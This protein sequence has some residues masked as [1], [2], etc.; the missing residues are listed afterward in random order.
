MSSSGEVAD[1]T[2]HECVGKALVGVRL[3]KNMKDPV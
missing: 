3:A 2:P 1:C